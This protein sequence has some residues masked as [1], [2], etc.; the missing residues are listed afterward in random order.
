MAWYFST[1]FLNWYICSYLTFPFIFDLYLFFNMH[2]HSFI[3]NSI[4]ERKWWKSP[5]Y[6]KTIIG[7][8]LCWLCLHC[9]QPGTAG[10]N[11]F[12]ASSFSI[13]RN[14]TRPNL[15]WEQYCTAMF[16]VHTSLAWPGPVHSTKLISQKLLS[17]ISLDILVLMNAFVVILLG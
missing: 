2:V 4:P 7:N 14:Y 13:C 10:H 6:H 12:S 15:T 3:H 11:E 9:W 5:R 8:E 17:Q 1:M 16:S